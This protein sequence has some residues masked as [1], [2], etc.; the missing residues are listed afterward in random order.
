VQALPEILQQSAAEIAPYLVI[1]CQLLLN[2]IDSF[3]E[4][5][6]ADFGTIPQ[7]LMG[8]TS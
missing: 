8:F 2:Q 5:F 3:S 4:M 6:P 1:R 7:Q